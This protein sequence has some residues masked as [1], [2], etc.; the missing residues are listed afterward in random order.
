MRPEDVPLR[1]VYFEFHQIGS[2]VRVSAI[3]ARTN[4]EVTLV[5]DANYSEEHL[6]QAA[7]RKLRYVIAKKYPSSD[8]GSV[9]A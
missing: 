3:D 8:D 1:Q 9:I 2:Y 5:G 4:I 7:I 6:K